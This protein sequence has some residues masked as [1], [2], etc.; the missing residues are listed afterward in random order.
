[1]SLEQRN[2][3][4]SIGDEETS[5]GFKLSGI[6]QVFT[7]EPKQAASL[8]RTLSEDPEIAIL[9][10]TEDVAKAN[11]DL[12]NRIQINPYPVIVEVPGKKAK[13]ESAEDRVRAL[14]KMALG[15]DVEAE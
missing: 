15:I 1:M 9:I 6:S 5:L 12:I 4:V 2:K 3:I 14:I 13:Y 8:L 10:I 11:R 7:E